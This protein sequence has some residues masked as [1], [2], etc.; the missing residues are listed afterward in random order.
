MDRHLAD[1]DHATRKVEDESLTL[2]KAR[3][4]LTHVE[5]ARALVQGVAK[6]VQEQA[7]A[8]IAGVV[9]RCLETVFDDPYTF[10]IR[11]DSK[12][13]KT[14]ARLLLERDG[15]ILENPLREAGGGVVDVCALALR[16]ACLVLSTPRRRRFL[17][18]DEPLKFLS[19]NYQPRVAELLMEL[20][21]EMDIQFLIVTHS[22]FLKL[23]KVIEL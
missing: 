18:L 5:G 11:F 1:L 16:L 7:H 21:E 3:A 6:E 9:S 23:G 8:R 20:A 15:L 2:E 12:R 4:Y 17:C 13:G 19:V 22:K 10:H 14:E